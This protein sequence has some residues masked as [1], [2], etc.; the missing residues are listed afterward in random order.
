MLKLLRPQDPVLPSLS[1]VDQC[2]FPPQAGAFRDGGAGPE[3]WDT[4]GQGWRDASPSC[5][6]RCLGFLSSRGPRSHPHRTFCVLTPAT[7]QE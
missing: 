7:G 5:G 6:L 2:S 3:L 4:A 1:R